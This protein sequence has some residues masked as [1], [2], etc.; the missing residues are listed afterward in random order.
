MFADARCQSTGFCP[1]NV[2]SCPWLVPSTGRAGLR[3]LLT[4]VTLTSNIRP[5][6]DPRRRLDLWFRD[7]GSERVCHGCLRDLP[8]SSA[9]SRTAVRRAE[10][11]CTSSSQARSATTPLPRSAVAAAFSSKTRCSRRG[12]VTLHEL[13]DAGQ[14]FTVDIQNE[15]IAARR[16]DETVAI[17]PDLIAIL[18]RE[19]GEP[20]TGEMLAY[21][22]RVKVIGY[23]ADAKLRQPESLDV[24]GPLSFGLDEPFIAIED[25][26]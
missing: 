11:W 14:V 3:G 24:L 18:D 13:T 5:A 1:K 20:L 22:Q 12:R 23:A 4:G 9:A 26:A 10:P 25:R 7:R 2:G 16:N 21:G 17:V 8:K 19:T 15:F 6:I